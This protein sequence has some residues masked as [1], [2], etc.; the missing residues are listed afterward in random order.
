L[1]RSQAAKVTLSAQTITV[2]AHSSR[3]VVATFAQP[4]GED[5]AGAYPVY[6]GFLHLRSALIE[7]A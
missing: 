5:F 4:T 2:P 1:L 7:Y 3:Q 6:S